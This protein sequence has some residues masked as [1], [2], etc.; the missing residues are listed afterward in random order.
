MH[1]HKGETFRGEVSFTTD[2][3]YPTLEN[4]LFSVVSDIP[5]KVIDE[6]TGLEA[7]PADMAEGEMEVL[8]ARAIDSTKI[9]DNTLYV[10]IS[11]VDDL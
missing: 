7:N 5:I 9:E 8:L 10:T 11:S 6:E 1:S 2:L 4:L 3:G